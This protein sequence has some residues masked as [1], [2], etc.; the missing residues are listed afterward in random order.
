MSN[1]VNVSELKNKFFFNT[2]TNIQIINPP[3]FQLLFSNYAG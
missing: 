2:V 1:A 3:K